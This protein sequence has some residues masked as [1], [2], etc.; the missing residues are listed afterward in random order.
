MQSDFASVCELLKI[1]QGR[2]ADPTTLPRHCMN[3]CSKVHTVD[4]KGEDGVSAEEYAAAHGNRLRL[5]DAYDDVTRD[6]VARAWA[7][8]IELF[9]FSWAEATAL[10]A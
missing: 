5:A 1:P 8:D 2:C 4:S 9:N 6:L 7:K 3:S 10:D